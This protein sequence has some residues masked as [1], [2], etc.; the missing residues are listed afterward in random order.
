MDAITNMK[1]QVISDLND[2]IKD[3]NIGRPVD[4]TNVLN[5]ITFIQSYQYLNKIDPAYEYLINI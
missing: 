4:F 2:L 1:M 3:L 5:K